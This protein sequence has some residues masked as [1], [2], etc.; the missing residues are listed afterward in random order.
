MKK[1]LIITILVIFQAGCKKKNLGTDIHYLYKK[2]DVLTLPQKAKKFYILEILRDSQNLVFLNKN[3]Y[4]PTKEAYGFIGFFEDA[5]TTVKFYGID[6]SI[7]NS[8]LL[9][10]LYYFKKFYTLP[11]SLISIIKNNSSP[12]ATYMLFYLDSI[13]P[14]TLYERAMTYYKN[15]PSL[16]EEET[17]YL[18]KTMYEIQK[19]TNKNLALLD[20]VI[21]FYLKNWPYSKNASRIYY[22][23]VSNNKIKNDTM[24]NIYKKLI[25]KN[26]YDPYALQFMAFLADTTIKGNKHKKYLKEFLKSM[27]KFPITSQSIQLTFYIPELFNYLDA[28]DTSNIIRR[29]FIDEF[30][31]PPYLIKLWSTSTLISYHFAKG[32]YLKSIKKYKEAISAFKECRNYNIPDYYVEEGD[33]Q[34]IDIYKKM[35]KYKTEDAKEVAL[36]LLSRN[37][38][39]SIGREV[40]GNPNDDSLFNMLKPILKKRAKPLNPKIEFTL[41]KGGKQDVK[42]LL[43]KAWI[44][45]FW[46]VYCPHCRR[47]IPYENELYLD[48]KDKKDFGFLACSLNSKKEV[49]KFLDKNAFYFTQCYGCGKLRRYF[50]I[51]GVP[52]YFVLDKNGN[53]VFSHIGEDKNIKSRLKTELIFAS[54]L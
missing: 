31:S 6:T 7:S 14:D 32:Y 38:V 42:K 16:N 2:G 1:L 21:N 19:G 48:L 20:S 22:Y 27:Q 49:E 5:D 29:N 26:P 35:G 51:S 37:P 47:E 44:I 25:L 10:S 53:I 23:L 13:S 3:T 24:I 39:D 11:S 8:S 41:L 30:G 33:R 34:I 4:S 28:E 9:V 54:K 18:V 40:I 43:G 45:K 15:L 36:D 17:Y 46:S 52:A 12:I 50:N